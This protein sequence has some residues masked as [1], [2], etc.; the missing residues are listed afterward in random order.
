VQTHF[1]FL[2]HGLYLLGHL[3]CCPVLFTI[4]GLASAG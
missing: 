2:G 4:T 1:R 3:Q